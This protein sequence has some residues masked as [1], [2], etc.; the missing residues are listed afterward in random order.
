MIV[1]H[2][3]KK[4]SPHSQK[5][6]I[7]KHREYAR[8]AANAHY[9][10]FLWKRGEKSGQEAN[11]SEKMREERL[12]NLNE[13]LSRPKSH[14]ILIIMNRIPNRTSSRKKPN[15]PDTNKNELASRSHLNGEDVQ[16]IAETCASHNRTFAQVEVAV[17]FSRQ[18]HISAQVW[19]S[20]NS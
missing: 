2:E 1:G 19:P 10:Q 18:R 7:S 9:A 11:N 6:I 14:P 12:Q 17:A 16:Q 8:S 20:W 5:K 13:G 3:R 4:I 15:I